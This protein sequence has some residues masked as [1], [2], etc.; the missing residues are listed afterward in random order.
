[1]RKKPPAMQQL[2]TLTL[3]FQTP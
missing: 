3:S 1:M 2:F